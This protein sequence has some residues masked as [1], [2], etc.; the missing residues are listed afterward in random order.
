V[1]L[2]QYPDKVYMDEDDK[3]GN[4]VSWNQYFGQGLGEYYSKG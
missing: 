3:E 2:K 1:N 4:N